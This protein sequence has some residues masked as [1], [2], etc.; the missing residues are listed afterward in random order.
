MKDKLFLK[1]SILF[2][3][4]FELFNF[5]E[6][7]LWFYAYNLNYGILLFGCA[8]HHDDKLTQI[9]NDHDNNKPL[10]EYSTSFCVDAGKPRLVFFIKYFLLNSIWMPFLLLWLFVLF[11]L[12]VSMVFIFFVIV[13]IEFCTCINLLLIY[14][15]VIF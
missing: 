13:K 7:H 12:Y 2:A 11:L 4:I 15:G 10:L 3:L 8:V 6:I 5:L 1:F 14:I 9:K